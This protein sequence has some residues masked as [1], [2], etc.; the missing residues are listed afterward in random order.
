MTHSAENDARRHEADGHLVT[1]VIGNDGV[2]WAC[3]TCG[4]TVYRLNPGETQGNSWR[5]FDTSLNVIP[6]ERGNR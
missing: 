3:R 2:R 6:P 4:E 5:H 1:T